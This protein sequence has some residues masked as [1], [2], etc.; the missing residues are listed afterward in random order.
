MW[1]EVRYGVSMHGEAGMVRRG[2]A[3]FSAVR[4]GLA[5]YGR[6]GKVSSGLVW[7]VRQARL[8]MVRHGQ[9]RYGRQT[10]FQRRQ[11]D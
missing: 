1:G 2:R 7:R 3:R 6:Q 11:A 8:G 4:Y 5:L 10:R 9:A